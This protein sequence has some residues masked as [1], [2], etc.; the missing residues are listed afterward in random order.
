M[1]MLVYTIYK[2]KVTEFEKRK[3]WCITCP[4][5]CRS[6][7]KINNLNFNYLQI[8][9]TK[10]IWIYEFI[11]TKIVNTIQSSSIQ[12]KDPWN[13]IILRMCFKITKIYQIFSR[14]TFTKVYSHS[15]INFL[16]NRFNSS[17]IL[18]N[19]KYAWFKICR[20]TKKFRYIRYAKCLKENF[21]Y[22]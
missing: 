21:C 13:I 2:F 6:K 11:C 8:Y 20:N 9:F 14:L 19:T 16:P 18:C 3:T 10:S 12:M 5:S 17:C 7:K 1:N 15:I 22:N 4:F